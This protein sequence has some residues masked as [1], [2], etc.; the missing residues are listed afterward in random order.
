MNLTTKA[1]VASETAPWRPYAGLLA[2]LAIIFAIA[3]VPYAHRYRLD[4]TSLFGIYCC[5]LLL[6]SFALLPGTD[7]GKMLASRLRTPWILLGLCIPYLAY[8]FGTGDFRVNALLRIAGVAMLPAIVY[9]LFPPRDKE[10]FS[11]GDLLVACFL[12]AVVLGGWLRGIW[13]IPVNLDF[14]GRLLLIAAAGIA[15]TFIR[16]VPGLGYRLQLTGKAFR[17]AGLNFLYF[18]AIAVPAG[19]LIGFTKWNPRWRGSLS[20]ALDFLEIF[21]FIAL[22]EEM[23]FRGFLQSLLSKSL[24]SE[25]KGQLLVSMLFG[26]FHILHA[27][28]PNW[29]YVALASV[30]GWFYGQA[31]RRG[32]GLLASSLTHAMVDTVWR[33]WFSRTTAM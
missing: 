12:I 22:L 4:S 26:L 24:R 33:T 19:L 11:I 16:P 7:A 9:R 29:R 13:T 28:F 23:F 18:A 5:F 6:L 14:M 20:F 32:G 2:A 17:Q 27:P 21:L 3:A 25:F 10:R 31:F 30:A 15:W 1:V 8:A